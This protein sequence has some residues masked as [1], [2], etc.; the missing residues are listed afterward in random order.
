MLGEPYM[1]F[2]VLGSLLYLL[3][4]NTSTS[5]NGY[6]QK[7]IVIT[8]IEKEKLKKEF[9]LVWERNASSQELGLILDKYFYDEALLY[10][11][12]SLD[13]ARNDSEIRK[14]LIHKMKLI[15]HSSTQFTEPTEEILS[16]YYQKNI[17][18][19]SHITALSFAHIYFLKGKTKVLEEVVK[20]LNRLHIPPKDASQ[21]GEAFNKGNQML[22]ATPTEIIETFGRYFTRELLQK[23]KGKWFGPIHS[24]EGMHIIYIKEKV[25]AKAYPF[26]EVESRVYQDYL[27]QRKNDSIEKSYQKI[28]SQYRVEIQ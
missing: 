12:E 26:E 15:M 10:E 9:Y 6:T 27:R 14:K 1:H 4:T 20:Q 16:L 23:P 17:E 8:A 24:K 22:H 18:E 11:A 19:Y 5:S 3:Y 28:L 25:I 7:S 13:I 2:I 21:Y